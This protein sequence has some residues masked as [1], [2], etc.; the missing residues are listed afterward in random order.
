MTPLD[1]TAKGLRQHHPTSG[2]CLALPSPAP[3]GGDLL[4]HFTQA[5]LKGHLLGYTT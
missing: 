2:V 4:S 1:G 3:V 5:L